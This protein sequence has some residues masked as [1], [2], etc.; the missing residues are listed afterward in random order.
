MNM[1]PH[2]ETTGAFIG[3]HDWG[4]MSTLF[5]EGSQAVRDVDPSMVD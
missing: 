3:E 1:N 2:N 4:R 5:N